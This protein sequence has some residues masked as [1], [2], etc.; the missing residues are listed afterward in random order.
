MVLYRPRF[1]RRI[2]PQGDQLV[3]AGGLLAFTQEGSDLLITTLQ[4]GLPRAGGRQRLARPRSAA[5]RGAPCARDRSPAAGP[6]V[7]PAPLARS[8]RTVWGAQRPPG[9]APRHPRRPAPA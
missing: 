9:P 6:L 7:D 2:V 4:D 8:D 5:R 1:V 3:L